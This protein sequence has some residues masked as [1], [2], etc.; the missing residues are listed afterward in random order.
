MSKQKSWENNGFILCKADISIPA[1]VVLLIAVG[2]WLSFWI[3]NESSILLLSNYDIL[4]NI[5]FFFL[6]VMASIIYWIDAKQ[7]GY[8]GLIIVIIISILISGLITLISLTTAIIFSFCCCLVFIVAI[9]KKIITNIHR[10]KG[11]FITLICYFFTY[12]VG[13]IFLLKNNNYRMARFMSIL[14]FDLDTDIWKPNTDALSFFFMYLIRQAN[15]AF[16]GEA[17]FSF[18]NT[19]L[20]V[21]EILRPVSR[22]GINPHFMLTYAWLKFGIIFCVFIILIGCGL[23]ISL[24]RLTMRQQ[25]SFHFINCIAITINIS[26]RFMIYLLPNLGIFYLNVYCP[27]ISGSMVFVTLDVFLYILFIVYMTYFFK[28]QNKNGNL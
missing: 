3:A 6:P 22:I 5:V 20:S 13:L 21:D 1:F 9:Q 7:Y 27:F 8:S 24:W 2:R 10:T 18:I 19:E 26:T 4:E 28:K 25:E 23:C 14:R 16:V 11:I 12:T 15:V 17:S